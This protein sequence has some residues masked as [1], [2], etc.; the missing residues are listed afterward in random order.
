MGKKITVVRCE[1]ATI[2]GTEIR[3][4]I[5]YLQYLRKRKLTNPTKGPF[6][7]RSPADIFT[8]TVRSM[9]P[10]YTKRGMSALHSLIAYEGIP[11]NMVR[12][13]GRC[14]IPRAQRHQ[15]YR[16]E[17]PYTVLGNMCQHVGWKYSDV[18]KKLETARIEKAT[19][20]YKK[21][22]KLRDAWKNARKQALNKMPKKNVEVLKKFGLA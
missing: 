17:R 5:K 14:V 18:V 12:K 7:H 20:H 22:Q 10:R 21:Q 9:L 8:R 15:C 3:N 6:H 1:Q 11:A 2:A 13:G 4:K 19:R 16:S